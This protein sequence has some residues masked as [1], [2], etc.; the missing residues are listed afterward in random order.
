[1]ELYVTKAGRLQ[2]KRNTLHLIPSSEKEPAR[3]FPI[4]NTDAVHLLGKTDIN[5]DCIDLLSEHHVPAHF[6]GWHGNH[7]GTFLPHG[8]Q[9][10][11][12]TVIAQVRATEQPSSRKRIASRLIGAT[13]TNMLNVLCEHNGPK[14]QEAK[15]LITKNLEVVREEPPIQEIMGLEGRSRKAYYNAWEELL[16]EKFHRNYNPPTNP[17]NALLSFLYSLL[18]AVVTG[19]L[20]RTHLHLGISFLHAPQ[21]RRTSLSLDVCEPF[22]P[23][24]AER[25]LIRLWN[26]KQITA[27]SFVS[28][29]NGVFLTEEAKREVVEAWF[30]LLESTIFH[31][32]LQK[33]VSKRRLIRLDGY[34]LQRH[35]LEGTPY[36][37]FQG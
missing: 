27:K 34:N 24:L 12:E 7:L 19:E 11:G 5:S 1:M 31:P 28:Q 8:H 16:G 23:Y 18:Y 4:E 6:Y 20:Y 10:S 29:S 25:L 21:E 26:S 33:H 2:R 14:I 37:P 9:V 15:A 22:K 32:K 3:F 30:D 13:L 35:L 36:E 17:I